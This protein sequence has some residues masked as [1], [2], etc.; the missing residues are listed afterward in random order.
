MNAQ[1]NQAAQAQTPSRMQCALDSL[2]SEVTNLEE[3]ARSLERKL[4]SVLEP[5]NSKLDTQGS[6]AMP[7]MPTQIVGIISTAEIRVASVR[8]QIQQLLDRLHV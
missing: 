8:L 7:P 4:I 3:F 5:E 6:T 2:H 1:L